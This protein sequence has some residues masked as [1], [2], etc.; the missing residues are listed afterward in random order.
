ML[1][2]VHAQCDYLTNPIGIDKETPV[3]GWKLLSDRNNTVQQ[4]YQ[5]IVHQGN[6]EVWDSGRIE[7]GR[8]FAIPYEGD[9]LRSR[10]EYRYHIRIW[11]DADQ[12][13][14]SGEQTFETAFLHH[15]DWK[16]SFVEPA[17]LGALEQN[18][19]TAAEEIWY[20]FVGKMMRGEKTEYVDMDALIASLPLQP[21][22]PAVMI[23]KEFGIS[24]KLEK[25]RIYMTAHGVYDI[26]VNGEAIT[27]ALLAPEYTSYDKLLKYQT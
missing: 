24:K 14:V 22:H 27:D 9:S 3:F 23:R 26:Q 18:P 17:P 7:S 10:M 25:A 1:Q 11:D 2:I 12:E 6:S 20:D 21:Y 13:I 16:A 4:A 8:S 5:I 15:G 19:Y